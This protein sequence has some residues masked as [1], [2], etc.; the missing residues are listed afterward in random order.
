MADDS[1]H[2]RSVAVFVL[3]LVLSLALSACG[4]DEAQSPSGSP[5]PYVD[6]AGY[7]DPDSRTAQA[8]ADAKA[9][10][11]S[12]ADRV[13]ARLA[14]TPQGIWLT[15]EQY[16]AGQVGPFV[17]QVVTAADAAGEIPTFVIYG[18]P[19]R[20]CSGGYSGGGLPADQYGPWVQEIADAA[21]SGEVDSDV[22]VIVEPDALASAVEC[23][24][25][26]ERVSLI[27]DAVSTLGAAGLTTY[28][29]GGHSHWIDPTDL[30]GLLERV[31]VDDVRGFAT[32]VANYQTDLDEQQYAEELSS[33]LG[34]D[35]HYVIDSGRNGNGS[36]E[37]WC[38]P[39]GRALGTAPSA[40]TDQG[41]LD[42]YVWVKPPG[43][44]DGECNGGPVAGEF[45]PERAL[46][47]G[48]AS[49]W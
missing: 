45:W 22:A 15:P 12:D 33:A 24:N 34:G 1:R 8:A 26:D 32:N 48:L 19:D 16:P 31:G 2:L 10:G 43:E 27:S 36:T 21:A 7:A 9:S 25:I 49:G 14:G 18:I 23:D 4:G 42:A 29:D 41:H 6:G 13:Y 44:S 3:G 11:E 30:A 5:N 39:S 20:D 47:L 40:V 17:T 38:N 37:E 35:A 28:V 46:E